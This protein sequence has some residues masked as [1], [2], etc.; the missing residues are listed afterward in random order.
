[1]TSFHH[2]LSPLVLVF[3]LVLLLV[4]LR[5]RYRPDHVE[6]EHHVPITGQFNGNRLQDGRCYLKKNPKIHCHSVTRIESS[7][8]KNGFPKRKKQKKEFLTVPP[9]EKSTRLPSNRGHTVP[10]FPRFAYSAE[11]ALFPAAPLETKLP[12]L[13]TNVLPCGK[14]RRLRLDSSNSR[15]L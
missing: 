6:L 4:I 5:G 14:A 15:D 2:P 3:V 12:I 1:M 8:R 13:T 10:T 11:N 7:N 9:I